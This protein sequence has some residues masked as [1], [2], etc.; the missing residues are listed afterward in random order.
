MKKTILC[1]L[2]LAS[3]AISAFAIGESNISYFILQSFKRDFKDVTNVT[4]T[5]KTGLAEASFIL[6]NRKTEAFYNHNG[7]LFAVSQ[8]IDLDELPVRAKRAFAKRY[9]GYT[10][11]EA[12][13]FEESDE[14]SYYISA[15]NEKETIIIKVDKDSQL[16]I[17][18]KSKK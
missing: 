12:I 9:A 14:L 3:V 10:V 16:S 17:F 2:L 8:A 6:N 5:S 7:T 11:N 18:K 4:W 13:Q 15:E 1:A